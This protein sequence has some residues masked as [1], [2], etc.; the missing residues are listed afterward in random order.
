MTESANRLEQASRIHLE[1][2]SQGHLE[3]IDDVVCADFIAH[4]LPPETPP[5]PEAFKE[6]IRSVRIVFP[7][8]NY[9]VDQA[10]VSGDTVALHVTGHGTH[11]G[12]VAGQPPT[13]LHAT[14]SEMHFV[15]FEGDRIAEHWGVVDQLSALQQLGGVRPDVPK[16]VIDYAAAV[17]TIP[18]SAMDMVAGLSAY[19]S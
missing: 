12:E 7:D 3:A 2:L 18:D 19:G 16:L 1:A 14:W 5:G 10:V 9:T 15:R 8:L 17:I 13:G 11:G 6:F 4:L